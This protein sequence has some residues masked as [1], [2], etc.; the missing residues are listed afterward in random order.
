MRAAIRTRYG[1]PL[2]VVEV[3]DRPEPELTADGVLIE[4]AAGGLNSLDW[5]MA[6]AI[7]AL[8][9]TSEGFRAPRDVRL[10]EDV[11]G[12]VIAV[13]AEAQGFA[14]GDRV[15]GQARGSFAERVVAKPR[16]LAHAPTGIPLADAAVLPVAGVTALQGLA[17]GDVG[18]GSRVLVIGAAG[19]VGGFAV[20]I[21]AA[22]GADVAGVCRT[23]N[24][25]LVRQFG[26]SRVFDYTRDELE[27]QYDYILEMAVTAPLGRLL[28]LLAPTG[29]LVLASGDGGSL[30][31]PLPRMARSAV[32]KRI[33]VL[34][35]HTRAEPLVELASLVD[36]GS[37]RPEITERYP[38]ERA[39]EAIAHVARGHTRGKMLIEPQARP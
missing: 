25:D 36:A 37:L 27:G 9:R 11:A 34:S 17:L 18:P 38:L 1:A 24:V 28:G 33:S 21:A 13:G 22:R 5:R 3:V 6:Q 2:D 10:G 4:V 8:V 39:A 30:I 29:R 16:H 19:G 26:A 12:T 7:P 35:A 23:A 32:D 20:Q 15:F 31:G 14:V